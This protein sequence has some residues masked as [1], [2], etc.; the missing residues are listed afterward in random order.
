MRHFRSFTRIGIALLLTGSAFAGSA[1]SDALFAKG[2]QLVLEADDTDANLRAGLGAYERALQLELSAQE[3]AAL[4]SHR[5]LAY[6]RLGDRQRRADEKAY[7]YDLGRQEAQKAIELDAQCADCYFIW[8]SNVGRYGESSG[9]MRSL[10]LLPKV[11]A[12][13]GRALEIDPK[14]VNT[15]VAQ[16]EL[17]AILPRIAGGSKRR[18]E[19][20]YRRALEIDPHHT[21]AMTLLAELLAMQGRSREAHAVARQAI[22]EENPSYPGEQRKFDAPRAKRLLR[23]G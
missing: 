3:Q 11:R 12:A 23:G 18:A 16:G 17:E 6:L 21:R 7:Y 19:A 9:I 8:G 13:F 10:Y 14:H 1:E 22:A 15:I 2:Q 20:H 5:A 4:Y